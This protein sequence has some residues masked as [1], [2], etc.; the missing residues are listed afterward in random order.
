[1][2][3]QD[4]FFFFLLKE[5]SPG[6]PGTCGVGSPLT[7]A[8][9]LPTRHSGT[10]GHTGEREIASARQFREWD[11]DEVTFPDPPGSAERLGRV[12][13]DGPCPKL[14]Q[15]PRSSSPKITHTHLPE[16]K[17]NIYCIVLLSA[18]LK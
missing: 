16:T 14:H 9:L 4:G 10:G 18:V 11:G 8:L 6:C 17:N 1:M 12:R 13:E 15:H 2:Y 5:A 7:T 3:N